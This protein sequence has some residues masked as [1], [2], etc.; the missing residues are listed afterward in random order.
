MTAVLWEACALT[1]RQ[2]W[3]VW[4]VRGL[5]WEETGSGHLCADTHIYMS[6]IWYRIEHVTGLSLKPKLN[7]AR[8]V[9]S[10]MDVQIQLSCYVRSLQLSWDSCS[11]YDL[12]KQLSEDRQEAS[13]FWAG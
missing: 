5:T 6:D 2:H 3:S 13:F 11:V 10:A 7:G 1:I 4:M 9:L 8:R 12:F